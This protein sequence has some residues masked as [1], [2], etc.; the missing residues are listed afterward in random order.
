MSDHQQANSGSDVAGGKPAGI[1]QENVVPI[2][3][4]SP[5]IGLASGPAAL[6]APVPHSSDC[7]ADHHA[8]A[9]PYCPRVASVQA[10]VPAIV[11]VEHS[12]RGQQ[13]QATCGRRNRL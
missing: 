9:W 2:L 4:T 7:P 11:G 12:G 13:R 3:E 8:A 1:F 6:S 10:M 5:A